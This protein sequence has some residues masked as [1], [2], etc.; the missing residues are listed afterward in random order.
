MITL[1]II[2][3]LTEFGVASEVW[4]NTYGADGKL[5]TFGSQQ[6]A[7]E[8]ASAH[9]TDKYELCGIECRKSLERTA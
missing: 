9:V 4:R 6:E 7:G 1:W 2:K 8:Y 5:L 3:R